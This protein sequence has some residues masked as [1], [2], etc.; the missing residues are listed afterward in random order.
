M[1]ATNETRVAVVTGSSRGL[2]AAMAKRLAADGFFV[3]VNYLRGESEA[4]A[5]AAEIAAGGGR[6]AV[7]QGDVSAVAGVDAFLAGVDAAL[8]RSGLPARFDVLVANAGIIQAKPFAEVT[9]ADFDAMVNTNLKGVFFLVQRS[10]GRLRDGG[11][12]I[13]LG[14][15]LSRVANPVYGP[16]SATKG[17]IDVLT[18]V[19]A[20][21]L[22]AR[23]ITVNTLAPG[24]IDTDMNPWLRS[25]A[26]R[27]MASANAALRRVGHADDIADAL[28]F[29]ASRD[30]R[31]VTA[32]RVEASG[33]FH[34]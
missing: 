29:L 5:V 30:S 22:G 13:T 15:G 2:G 32:Q 3:V 1:E 11:R 24:P 31:W 34:I 18:R 28:S 9:E 14:S 17:A 12:V 33:G 26:G 16:Y 20:K 27:D 19:W 6:A 7:V 25:D 8:A 21:D 23:G 4:H 10:L